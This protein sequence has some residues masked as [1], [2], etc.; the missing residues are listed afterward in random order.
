VLRNRWILAAGTLASLACAGLVIF[1]LLPAKPGVTWR[2][3][4]RIE[5]GMTKADA[6]AILG[7]PP[8]DIAPDGR[9]WSTLRFS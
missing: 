2:N 7:G 6:E 9:D 8:H 1:A 5:T 3:F 4:D